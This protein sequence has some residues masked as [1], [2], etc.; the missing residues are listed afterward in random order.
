MKKALTIIA[1]LFCLQ[2]LGQTSDKKDTVV[3]PV[4][5]I[6][7]TLEYKLPYKEDADPFIT[8]HHV[9]DSA[10]IIKYWVT[11]DVRKPLKLKPRSIKK[12]R[13]IKKKR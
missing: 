11:D 1:I 8:K 2:S 3:F 6:P 4:N 13:V 7:T 10:C 9:C 12:P 5:I